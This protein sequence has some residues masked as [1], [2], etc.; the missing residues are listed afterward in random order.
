MPELPEVETV[1]RGVARYCL[2]RTVAAVAASRARMRLGSRRTG[3]APLRGLTLTAAERRAKFLL[4]RFDGGRTLL[5][6]LG[7][8]GT[9]RRA[10]ATDPPRRHDHLRLAFTSGEAL[11]FNDARRFGLYELWRDGEL[12]ASPHLKKL[13]PEP[14]GPAFSGASLRVAAKRRRVPL[15]PLLMDPAVVVGVGNIYASESLFRARLSPRRAAAR[16]TR[17]E[18]DRLAAAVKVVLREAI[19]A[20]GTTLRDFVSP[21]GAE[22]YFRIKLA[23]YDRTGEPCRACQTPIRRLVQAGRATFYCPSCQ[24]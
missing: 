24:R 3:L 6:H 11:I 4:L 20:G 13:G 1:R 19:A 21:E 5:I 15:K 14:L 9:L 12:P 22:G 7:M 2:G 10:A 16:L 8:T 17:T 23:V 18:A